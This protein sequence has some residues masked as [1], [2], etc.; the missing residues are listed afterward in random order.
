MRLP[1]GSRISRR[2]PE[3]GTL[4]AAQS[5]SKCVPA[6]LQAI[7][8]EGACVVAAHQF[9]NLHGECGYVDTAGNPNPEYAT[10][11]ERIR[12]L[13]RVGAAVIGCY[14]ETCFVAS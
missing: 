14:R 1:N 9:L 2:A 4:L 5:T 3:G 13:A 11:D 10:A 6:D 8:W 7:F 12:S